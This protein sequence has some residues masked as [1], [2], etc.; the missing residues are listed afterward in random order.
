MTC[1]MT[2]TWSSVNRHLI[3]DHDTR[4]QLAQSSHDFPHAAVTGHTQRLV[5]A[6]HGVARLRAHQIAPSVQYTRAHEHIDHRFIIF[7]QGDLRPFRRAR[8]NAA[9]ST[10]ALRALRPI[11]HRTFHFNAFDSSARARRQYP[12][13]RRDRPRSIKSTT[14]NHASQW[15]HRRRHNRAHRRL[16][17][18]LRPIVPRPVPPFVPRRVPGK[19]EQFHDVPRVPRKSTPLMYKMTNGPFCKSVE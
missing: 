19:C 1:A 10:G 6:R 14:G 9:G 17:G 15:G 2:S 13:S 8:A 11:L 3:V 18:G 16:L 12:Q 7:D 4:S 5:Q